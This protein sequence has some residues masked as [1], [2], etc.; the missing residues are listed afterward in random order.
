[1]KFLLAPIVVVAAVL[2]A[3]CLDGAKNHLLSADEVPDGLQVCPFRPWMEEQGYTSNPGP[4]PEETVDR[5]DDA[6][7]GH[8][9]DDVWVQF[10]ASEDA[11]DCDPAIFV[12]A[13]AWKAQSD[14]EAAVDRLVAEEGICDEGHV[15]F[16]K[17]TL[18]TIGSDTESS[19]KVDAVHDALTAKHPDMSD[20][21]P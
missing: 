16:G 19:E 8:P 7:G 11:E 15:L 4:A 9:P 10:V 20:P 13:A 1:M 21:C 6:T 17:K 3:G 18:I 5:L 14:A 12:A 2:L